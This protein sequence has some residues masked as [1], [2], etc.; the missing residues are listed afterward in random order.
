MKSVLKQ[1]A[2]FDKK[3][4]KTIRREG[5]SQVKFWEKEDMVLWFCGN[6]KVDMDLYGLRQTS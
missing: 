1:D 6:G 5:G 2:A 4:E 3:S